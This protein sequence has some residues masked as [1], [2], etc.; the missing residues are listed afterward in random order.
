M[1]QLARQAIAADLNAI[2]VGF[3]AAARR[4]PRAAK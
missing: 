3:G 2:G 1:V 4:F